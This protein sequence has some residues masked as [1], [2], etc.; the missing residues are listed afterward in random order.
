[1]TV[2]QAISKGITV[3]SA[4][5]VVAAFLFLFLNVVYSCWLFHFGYVWGMLTGLSS[6]IVGLAWIII[7]AEGAVTQ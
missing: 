5:G 7:D 1:M 6:A 3:S 4:I 2:K